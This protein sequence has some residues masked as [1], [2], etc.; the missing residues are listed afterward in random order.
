MG[1]P[2]KAAEISPG[3]ISARGFFQSIQN[4]EKSKKLNFCIF[5]RD[6]EMTVCAARSV[7]RFEK[8]KR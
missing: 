2:G 6:S 3:R 7:G 5:L 8:I 1:S 4:L